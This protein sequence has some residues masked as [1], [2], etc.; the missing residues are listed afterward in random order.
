MYEYVEHTSDVK[1]RAKGKSFAEALESLMQGLIDLM[2]SGNTAQSNKEK[3]TLLELNTSHINDLVIMS[4]EKILV[5][6]E[7]EN[8]IPKKAKIL[9]EEHENPYYV[10]F[11]LFGS[12]GEF[13]E[14]LIKAVT[15]HQLKVEKEEDGWLLEVIVDI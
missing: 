2:K 6:S 7:I 10:K 3:E 8:I 11:A 14:T 5:I 12:E 15:Y 13:N 4:L 1:I 9:E